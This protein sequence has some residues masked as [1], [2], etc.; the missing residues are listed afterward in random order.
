MR[1]WIVGDVFV[2]RLNE[3][4][5]NMMRADGEKESKYDNGSYDKTDETRV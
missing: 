4:L 1:V 2:V 3:R 5:G